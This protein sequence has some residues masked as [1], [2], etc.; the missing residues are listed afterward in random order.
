MAYE[1]RITPWLPMDCGRH[2]LHFYARDVL[3][4]RGSGWREWMRVL[5]CDL[6]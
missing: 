6:G 3:L 2:A 1:V 5:E 4:T